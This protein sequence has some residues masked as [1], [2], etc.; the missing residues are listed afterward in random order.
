MPTRPSVAQQ[1]ESV[2]TRKPIAQPEPVVPQMPQIPIGQGPISGIVDPNARQPQPP[3]DPNARQ[4]RAKP[5]PGT[6]VP[7]VP[8]GGFI[9]G[10]P[11][12]FNPGGGIEPAAM[13][14]GMDTMARVATPN[15]TGGIMGGFGG[16]GD[17]MAGLLGRRKT[18]VSGPMPSPFGPAIEAG[19]INSPL[20]PMP[21]DMAQ[22]PTNTGPFK[23]APTSPIQRRPYSGAPSTP[24]GR[25][26]GNF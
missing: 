15:P 11:P 21:P 25:G 22:L 7:P 5:Y 4:A 12:A 20:G 2:R 9:G 6:G 24:W 18:P 1:R 26:L 3:I 10:L 13:P 17:R 14:P 19:A 16:L 23:P 8:G